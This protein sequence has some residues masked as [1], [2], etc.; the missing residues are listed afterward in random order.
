[1]TITKARQGTITQR[2]LS[3]PEANCVCE[4][5]P[6]GNHAKDTRF[7]TRPSKGRG[8]RVIVR[9]DLT[10]SPPNATLL[11]AVFGIYEEPIR[12]NDQVITLCRLT[13][14]WSALASSWNKRDGIHNW[15]VPGGTSDN[16]PLGSFQPT[17]LGFK[18]IDVT[19]VV[20]NWL[21]GTYDNNGF[22]LV[23][24]MTEDTDGAEPRGQEEVN[25]EAPYLDLI[26]TSEGTVPTPVHS[27]DDWP[28]WSSCPVPAANRGR[29]RHV[30]VIL[31][32]LPRIV[33]RLSI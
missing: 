31:R 3:A 17:S 26:Y 20:R 23:A 12:N 10:G 14:S 28:I 4:D 24:K 2:S 18:T 33:T 11:S 29:H 8:S 9:F 30:M 6:D 25:F 1:M 32:S 13:E 19:D 27:S 15:T 22:I 16:T 21:N 5:G 7:C